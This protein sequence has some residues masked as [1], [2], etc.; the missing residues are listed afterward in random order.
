MSVPQSLPNE[1][2]TGQE[3][4]AQA[5]RSC[6][7][8]RAAANAAAAAQVAIDPICGMQ[9]DPATTPHRAVRAGIDYHFCSAHCRQA[10]IDS[11]MN[12]S[13]PPRR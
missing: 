9:V 1:T 4:E 12:A 10:F 11:D 13:A 6:C 5:P 3:P 7:S 2:E 8:S